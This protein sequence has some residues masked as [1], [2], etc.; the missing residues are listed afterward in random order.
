MTPEVDS[1]VIGYEEIDAMLEAF[2]AA[3]RKR[4]NLD[5]ETVTQWA[6]PNPQTFTKAQRDS[7]TLLIGGLTL[8]HD[9]LLTSAISG[10]G[11]HVRPLDV[12]DTDASNPS[13]RCPVVSENGVLT[14]APSSWQ[15]GCAA[16]SE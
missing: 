4:M 8:A 1:K 15:G 6:D 3:E 11:Y 16:V 2:E 12:P 9:Q 13:T 10:L 7:T 5:Q 14:N